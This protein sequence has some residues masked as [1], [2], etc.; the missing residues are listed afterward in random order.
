MTVELSYFTLTSD[1]RKKLMPKPTPLELRKYNID[2]LILKELSDLESRIILFSIIKQ[3][4][5]PSQISHYSQIPR[6][7]VY[8][9][10]HTLETLGLVCVEKTELINRV[11]SRYYRSTIREA[12]ICIKKFEPIVYLI[13]N[14]N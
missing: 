9:K 7:T 6:S 10:L 5:L 8:K 14:E 13:P 4:K 12:K 1:S 3:S 2:Q 11:K